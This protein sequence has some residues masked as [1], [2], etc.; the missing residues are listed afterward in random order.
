MATAL[1]E[2]APGR[3]RVSD[4]TMSLEEFLAL[5]EEENTERMLIR[6]RLSE[7][8]LVTKRNRFHSRLTARISYLLE[9]WLQKH[10]QLRGEVASGEAGAIIR[11]EPVATTVGIDVAYFGPDV[12]ASTANGTSLYERAPVL[13]VEILSPHKTTEEIQ[14]KVVEYLECGSKLVWVVEPRRRTVTVYRPDADP[15]LFNVRQTIDGDSSLPGLSLPVVE[16]FQ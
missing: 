2:K 11:H 4:E 10:S 3:F 16:M 14:N 6:G 13:A 1:A 5:P 12:T 9:A 8:S 7:R 15:V